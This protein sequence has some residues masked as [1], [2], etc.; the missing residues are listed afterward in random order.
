M[1]QVVE[2]QYCPLSN[3]CSAVYCAESDN[4]MASLYVDGQ[5]IVTAEGLRMRSSPDQVVDSMVFHTFFG[6]SGDEWAAA[7][8]EV[9]TSST[10]CEG[11]SAFMTLDN[12]QFRNHH[13]DILI[14]MTGATGHAA[15]ESQS[16][17]FPL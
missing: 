11:L 4:G 12:E 3:D 8:D 15:S 14:C 5:H 13:Y 2:L 1:L 17:R 6:G 9:L 10:S 16:Q 7:K